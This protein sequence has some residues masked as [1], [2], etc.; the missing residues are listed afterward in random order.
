M[1]QL[2]EGFFDL[3]KKYMIIFWRLIACDIMVAML[4][5]ENNK[6]FILWELTSIL[7]QTMWT[8]LILF[9]H[10]HSSKCNPPLW[11]EAEK[12]FPN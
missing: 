8:N 6:I 10:Q 7:M 3:S 11:K 2:V 5:G 12:L 9:W 1:A 4:V